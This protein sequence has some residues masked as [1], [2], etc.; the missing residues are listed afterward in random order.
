M[1]TRIE[2]ISSDYR[3]EI[4]SFD[5]GISHII[6]VNGE[7]KLAY[8]V[9]N[10]GVVGKIR[11]VYHEFRDPPSGLYGRRFNIDFLDGSS[12]EIEIETDDDIERYLT[13]RGSLNYNT[14]YDCI[15]TEFKLGKYRFIFENTSTGEQ[16]D[17][18]V[19]VNMDAPDKCAFISI[20]IGIYTILYMRILD[21]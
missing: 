6:K 18:I 11:N 19:S 4:A 10:G 5:W 20:D 7:N 12:I 2:D 16:D 1:T 15:R 8:E 17:L 9:F 13:I 3:G 14:R 21:K